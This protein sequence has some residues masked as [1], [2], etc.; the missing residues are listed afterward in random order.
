MVF[1]VELDDLIYQGFT[2]S[3][4]K[5]VLLVF[6]LL[7]FVTGKAAAGAPAA[8]GLVQHGT[9][10]NSMGILT[11]FTL[12]ASFLALGDTTCRLGWMMLLAA[13]TARLFERGHKNCVNYSFI[14]D[15]VMSSLDRR[16]QTVQT[17]SEMITWLNLKLFRHKG[18]GFLTLAGK[19]C[20]LIET[21]DKVPPFPSSEAMSIIR[22]ELGQDFSPIG[23]LPN[24]SAAPWI[25]AVWEPMLLAWLLV[26]ADLGQ[27]YR[28]RLRSNRAEVAVQRPGLKDTLILDMFIFRRLSQLLNNW[29]QAHL[30][31]NV[32]L[33]VDEFA[34]KLWEEANY[35]QEAKNA[36]MF[37][38]NFGQD[39]TVKIPKVFM[40]YVSKK[41]I[42]M[43]WIDGLKSTDL[44]GLRRRGIDIN[45]F[46][47]NGVQAA[48]RQL[49]EFGLFHGDPHA[50]NIF[51]MDDGRIAYVDFGN[52]ANISESQRDVLI[53]A[54]T[55]VSNSDYK[56]IA[57]DFIRL[58]FLRPGTDVSEI[59]P[60]METIWA[61]S[62]GKSIKDFNFRTVTGRFSKL[63]YQFPIRIPERFSLVI[64]SLLMQEGICMC[65]NPDFSIIEV[66]LPY[67][68]KRLLSNPNPTLRRELLSIVFSGPPERPVLQWD[69]LTNLV[70]LAKQARDGTSIQI[71]QVI[72]DFF[73]G[74]RRDVVNGVETGLAPAKVLQGGLQAL[75]AGDRLRLKDV[76]QLVELLSPDL[77][78]A[79][80]REVADALIRD[81]VEDVLRERG[82]QLELEDF[83]PRDPRNLGKVLTSGELFK[84]LP[85][86]GAA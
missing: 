20:A 53:G 1:L 19:L 73:R 24:W 66:A 17:S 51:A 50:G 61:D 11:C 69:R 63:V 8:E 75:T 29:A 49:L 34:S 71:N 30:G 9:A 81:S 79:L 36:Q 48:L 47:R 38:K 59:V 35:E 22:E 62:M 25:S 54:I 80:A 67:A 41:V 32:T 82:V 46:I 40:Q 12:V 84:L 7:C 13:Q 26:L 78:P 16:W 21:E 14:W 86:P 64:R 68:S 44:A 42:T 23:C 56:E 15:P 65:L 58:G 10:W 70:T 45:E 6:V 85:V 83:D 74:L 57:N 39:P 43:E 5:E 77:T 60:A 37:A 18:T 31:C 55:H 33:V 72:V 28:G 76:L 27:V 2:P 4:G 52:V 3:F